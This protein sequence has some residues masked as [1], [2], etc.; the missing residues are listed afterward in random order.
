MLLAWLQVTFKAISDVLS[1]PHR[2]LADEQKACAEPPPWEQWHWLLSG[3]ELASATVPPLSQLQGDHQCGH[4]CD[5]PWGCAGTQW[6]GGR[7]G[8]HRI[9]LKWDPIKGVLHRIIEYLRLEKTS[10]IIM[11]D[12]QAVTAINPHHG[13]PPLRLDMHFTGSWSGKVPWRAFCTGTVK[14][15]S[16]FFNV[17]V[18]WVSGTY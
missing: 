4:L 2:L 11:S 5:A 8:G 10:K 18:L 1:L 7:G 13:D 9:S 3:G 12:R 15:W 16:K 6:S 14:S 17:E